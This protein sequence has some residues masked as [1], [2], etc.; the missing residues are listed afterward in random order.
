MDS[1]Q[2]IAALHAVRTAHARIA[3]AAALQRTAVA[4]ARQ[5]GVQWRLIAEAV[6][7]EQANASRKFG[8]TPRPSGRAD[9]AT[10]RP[11]VARVAGARE[12]LLD[13]EV[14]EVV[15]IARARDAGVSWQA[16]ADEIGMKQP[17]AVIKFR[18]Y[19]AAYTEAGRDGVAALLRTRWART[20][21]A[22]QGPADDSPTQV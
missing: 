21:R 15:A 18:P 11:A 20:S 22:G 7:M 8:P 13:A 1:D 10:A 12:A 4:D 14:A 16:I 17:N 2:V 3:D 19:I 5:A 6:G 9:E